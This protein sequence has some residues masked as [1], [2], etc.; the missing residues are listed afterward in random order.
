M[1]DGIMTRRRL[2]L[3]AL[4]LYPSWWRRHY[5][6]EAAAILE[7]TPPSARAALDL[8]R[9][10]IDAWTRQRPPQERFG[11]FGDEARQVIVLAQKEAH[12]LD[13]NYVGTE[14]ILLGLLA[15]PDSIAGR[16]LTTLGVSSERVRERLLQIVGQ[17]IPSPPAKCSRASSSPD[18]PKWSMRI[19]PRAKHG[20]ALSC[21]AADRLGD[22]DVDPA[23]LLLGMLDEGEGVG[24]KILAE[25]ADPARVREELARLRNR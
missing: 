5:G 22:A 16:A 8:L 6:A 24:V 11:R 12:A 20:L 19:T 10:A 4:A 1:G 25:L 13:H 15:A 2:L 14:H 18:L 23:H 17:G 9:G 3:F 7:Q 21:T